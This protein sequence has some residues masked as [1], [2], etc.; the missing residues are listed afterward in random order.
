M[1]RRQ[2]IL[3]GVSVIG[4]CAIVAL[5]AI[6]I[7]AARSPKITY[8]PT[9]ACH[10]LTPQKATQLLGS[11]AIQ[12]SSKPPTRVGDTMTS[13]CGYTDGNQDT[14]LMIVAAV[15]I[16]SGVNDKGVAENKVAFAEAGSRQSNKS[17]QGIGDSAFFD[18]ERGQ[19]NVLSERDWMIISY[20]IG[21]DPLSNTVDDTTKLAREI[22]Q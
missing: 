5:V 15:M 13:A 21:A 14:N 2:M 20:G 7:T 16:R 17:V 1:T 10:R 22:L 6:A 12:S 9:N 19:L 11:A 3:I 4:V 18:P 8:Q